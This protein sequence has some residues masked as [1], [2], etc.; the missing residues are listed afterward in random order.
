ME[1]NQQFNPP[2]MPLTTA[3]D[4]AVNQQSGMFSGRL[5]RLGYLLGIVY[6]LLPIIAAI[7]LFAIIQVA[8][9]PLPGDNTLLAQPNPVATIANLLIFILVVLDVIIIIPVSLSIQIRRWHDMNLSGWYTLLSFL[10]IVGY[11][12]L[13]VILFI[14]GTQST[15]QFGEP[16]NPPYKFKKVLFGR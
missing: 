1:P 6:S 10:P 2:V 4:S 13:I 12:A 9:R 8:F 7:V 16:F 5:G 3:V 11:I 15:N 14:P